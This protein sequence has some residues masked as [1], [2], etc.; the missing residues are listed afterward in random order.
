M[1]LPVSQL[2]V[3]T[4]NGSS[5]S[6]PNGTSQASVDNVL[7][8][9][10]VSQGLREYYI[11]S[12]SLTA[13]ALV[14]AY[15]GSLSQNGTFGD[16]PNIFSCKLASIVARTPLERVNAVDNTCSV[17]SRRPNNREPVGSNEGASGS[18]GGQWPP[19]IHNEGPTV[20]NRH[21]LFIG[22]PTFGTHASFVLTGEPEN[23]EEWNLLQREVQ[24]KVVERTPQAH[25][26]RGT[27]QWSGSQWLTL[28]NKPQKTLQG[29]LQSQEG[30]S[31]SMVFEP[32]G[33][34]SQ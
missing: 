11:T 9:D 5:A 16:F 14:E 12:H 22:D 24:K 4:G 19:P 26:W 1:P 33:D 15:H 18:R 23:Q 7:V 28:A 29:Y 27:I 25:V 10:V 3:G 8:C 20:V 13:A 30:G 21:S 17:F 6:Q 31:G 32:L 34:P 2:T